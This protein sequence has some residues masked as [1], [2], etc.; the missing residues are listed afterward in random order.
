[1]ITN[2][3]EW[4]C[5]CQNF[6]SKEALCETHFQIFV[7]HNAAQK[8][9]LK[10]TSSYFW[11]NVYSHVLKHTQPCLRCQQRKS[12]RNKLPPLAPL[13]IPDQPNLR[14][15]AD[16]FRP[17]LG[18]KRKVL[19][20]FPEPAVHRTGFSPKRLFTECPYIAPFHRT[21]VR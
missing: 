11:P 15:H 17:M 21:Y 8:S 12:S 20:V 13:L 6:C 4:P 9:Y 7:G 1:M 5:G 2:T 14:I 19:R 18:S 16:L 10:L 3:P